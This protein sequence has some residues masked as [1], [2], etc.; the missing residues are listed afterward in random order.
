MKKMNIG[1][2]GI[3]GAWS[4]ER[5]AQAV[6]KRTGY[7]RII[8]LD[9][10]TLDL[11]SGRAWHNELDLSRLDALVVKKVGVDYSPALMDRL[12]ILKFLHRR[13]TPVFSQPCRIMGVLNRLSCTVVLKNGGIPMPPTTITQD[14]DKAL[15]TVHR[16]GEAVFKPLFSTKARGMEVMTPGPETRQRIF[17]FAK[18]HG[19]MLHPEKN[20]I[21][22]PGPGHCL[23]GG[24]ISD[25]P[26]PGAAMNPPGTPPPGAAGP[27]SPLIRAPR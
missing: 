20:R 27:T 21:R 24:G 7:R 3:P 10:V 5:L 17:A 4:T 22:R 23:F 2:V 25:H 8:D 6:E 19:M 12:E 18:T 15:E 11:D 13:G 9:H 14:V 16:Y 26:M 1:V